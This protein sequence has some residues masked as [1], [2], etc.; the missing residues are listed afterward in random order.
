[1][2]DRNAVLVRMDEFL[3]DHNATSKRPMNLAMFLYA[4]E[5]VSR[6]CR[7]LKQPGNHLLN[8]GVG[9]SGRQSL[10]RLA[11]FITGIETLQIEISK[12]YTQVEWREDLKRFTRRCASLVYSMYMMSG[13]EVTC[14]CRWEDATH[15]EHLG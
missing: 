1:M 7:V 10:S 12:S 6:A 4:M 8:V 2:Q 9:G 14:P 5:H 11:A 3:V 15:A 13:T